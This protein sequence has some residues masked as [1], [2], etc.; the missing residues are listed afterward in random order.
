M[1]LTQALILTIDTETTGPDPQQDR[2]VELGGGYLQAG[3]QVGPMLRVLVD[4]ERYIPAGA[5]QVHGIRNEDVDGAPKWT[6][7]APRLKRHLDAE[8]VLCGYNILG[9]DSP[10]IDNENERNDIPWQMPRSLDPFIW[11]Y[12]YDRGAPSRKLGASC[13]RYGVELSEERA[14]TADADA[15]ATGLLLMSLVI[16]GVIPDDVE[17]AFAEQAALQARIDGEYKEY[18][19]FIFPDRE[20]GIFRLGLGKH[21]GT[22]VDEADHGYLKWLLGRP[23]ITATAKS[24]LMKALGQVEQIGLF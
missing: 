6:E 21:C 15:F 12:W 19:R 1:K 4:P 3:E 17:W 8:P 2:V 22:A 14:H 24:V 11:I 13:E 5:T 20:T 9:F 7:V 23:D 16:E 18:G 10:L